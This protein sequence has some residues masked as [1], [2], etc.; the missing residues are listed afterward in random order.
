MQWKWPFYAQYHIFFLFTEFGNPWLCTGCTADPF[1]V[2][3]LIVF[4]DTMLWSKTTNATLH[5][6]PESDI[7][8][9]DGTLLCSH[10]PRQVV[11]FLFSGCCLFFFVQYFSNTSSFP[12]LLHRNFVIPIYIVISLV[13]SFAYS[14]IVGKFPFS[15]NDNKMLTNRQSCANT[16]RALDFLL[17]HGI[18]KK[19]IRKR[20]R[21]LNEAS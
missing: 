7:V 2:R 15:R 14:C 9:G 17:I 18:I 16:S 21:L 20:D 8:G 12:L 5:N 19:G 13:R 6:E 1:I 10:W 11:C 3:T 4:I